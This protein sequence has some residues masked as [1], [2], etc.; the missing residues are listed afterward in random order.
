MRAV[1][2]LASACLHESIFLHVIDEKRPSRFMGSRHISKIQSA[3]RIFVFRFTEHGTGLT[4][5]CLADVS[6]VIIPEGVSTLRIVKYVGR[7]D[8]SRNRGAK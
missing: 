5:F 6:R 7:Y 8:I 1:F 4:E 2:D 3:V